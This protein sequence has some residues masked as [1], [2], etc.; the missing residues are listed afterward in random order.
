MIEKKELIKILATPIQNC[1]DVQNLLGVSTLDLLDE[2]ENKKV[3]FKYKKKEI[4]LPLETL[5]DIPSMRI[6]NLNV[7]FNQKKDGL[8]F[9]MKIEYEN[10]SGYGLDKLTE[11]LSDTL[12]VE[13]I[14][15]E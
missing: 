14:K 5:I 6:N 15:L 10:K 4:T 2:C 13:K 1:I 9:S 3:T 11:F 8:D 12:I 7:N